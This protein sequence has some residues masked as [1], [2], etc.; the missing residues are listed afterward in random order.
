MGCSWFSC[1]RSFGVTF[2]EFV[3]AG[4]VPYAQFTNKETKQKVSDLRLAIY[5][6]L[7]VVFM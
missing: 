5:I 6:E 3:T 2:Y 1:C 7:K 4:A